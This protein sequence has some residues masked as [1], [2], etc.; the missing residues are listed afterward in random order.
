MARKEFV[1]KHKREPN[2][3]EMF[4]QV[5]ATKKR[6]GLERVKPQPAL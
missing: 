6:L 5:A 1:E 3:G 2:T 4:Q